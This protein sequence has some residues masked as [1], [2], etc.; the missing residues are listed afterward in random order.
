MNTSKLVVL[1]IGRS[2]GSV[3]TLLLS[4]SSSDDSGE[5]RSPQ[6]LL[7][8]DVFVRLVS[9]HKRGETLICES[10]FCYD[11]GLIVD[12][13]QLFLSVLSSL[14]LVKNSNS[15]LVCLKRFEIE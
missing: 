6:R 12:S 10:I 5:W 14:R 1:S 15:S 3:I 13:Q 9:L 4:G 2:V 7:L 8:E 11:F